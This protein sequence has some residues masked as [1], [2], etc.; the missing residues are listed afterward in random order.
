MSPNAGGCGVSSASENSCAYH[1][2]WWHGGDL[3]PYLT[4]DLQAHEGAVPGAE[5][6]GEL[7]DG[8]VLQRERE[9]HPQWHAHPGPHIQAIQRQDLQQDPPTLMRHRCQVSTT[10]YMYNMFF[11]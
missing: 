5:G 9:L 6:G 2:T 1:V 4:Y 11:L 3:T 7:R 8:R 10:I